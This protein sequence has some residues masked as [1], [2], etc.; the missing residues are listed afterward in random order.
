MGTRPHGPD[1]LAGRGCGSKRRLTE[2]G[3][4]GAEEGD[5]LLE[6]RMIWSGEGK[7]LL[8]TFFGIFINTVPIA[9]VIMTLVGMG[10]SVIQT[11]DRLC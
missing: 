10:K 2:E 5:S 9:S 11:A 3:A 7:G 6:E 4:E 8:H 1:W